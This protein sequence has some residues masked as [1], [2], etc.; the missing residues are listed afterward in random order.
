MVYTQML[1]ALAFDQIVWGVSPGVISII[2]SSLILGS[3]IYVALHRENASH[4]MLVASTT[5]VTTADE[6]MGLGKGMD[7]VDEYEPMRGV[8]EVELRTVRA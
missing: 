2:G 3:A 4:K 7:D 1:F 5:V 6:E 8:D